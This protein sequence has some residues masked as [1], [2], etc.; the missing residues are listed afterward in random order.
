[1]NRIEV[2]QRI[3][4][5]INAKKY[6]EIGVEF[7]TLFFRIKAQKKIAVDPQFKFSLK[8]KIYKLFFERGSKF[9]EMS[10]DDF[11]KGNS[12]LFSDQKID[13][14]FVDGLHTYEQSLRDIENCLDNLEN[15]G[16]VVVHDCNPLSESAAN[17]SQDEAKKMKGW[18]GKWNGDVWKTIV[19]LRSMRNDL[20]IFV[21]NTDHGLGIIRKGAPENMLDHKASDIENMKYEDLDKDRNKLLNLKG[22]NYFDNFLNDLCAE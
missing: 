12:G 21:L 10:S 22:E 8:K 5:K 3:I 2:V 14:A 11:F 17:P 13:V 6:L 4:N 18:N 1:M 19:H 15:N 16:V 9:F 20:N 7:G